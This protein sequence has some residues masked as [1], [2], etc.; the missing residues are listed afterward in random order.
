MIEH[1]PQQTPR[2]SYSRSAWLIVPQDQQPLAELRTH[3][4]PSAAEG[5]EQD[6]LDAT[7]CPLKRS[8][9]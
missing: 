5:A 6:A 9:L 1:A 3:A 8:M 7:A 2:R 4:A